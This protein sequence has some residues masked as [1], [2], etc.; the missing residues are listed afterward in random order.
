M[1]EWKTLNDTSRSSELTE[2]IKVVSFIPNDR[3][4]DMLATLTEN[5]SFNIF[6][7]SKAKNSHKLLADVKGI[8]S[9][10]FCPT[11]QRFALV[12]KKGNVRIRNTP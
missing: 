11:G 10:S 7:W 9:F 3:G 2:S 6:C 5:G 8:V 1:D 12:D 4:K